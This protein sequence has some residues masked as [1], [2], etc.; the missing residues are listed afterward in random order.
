MNLEKPT[1][2]QTLSS[3]SFSAKYFD[4][5]KKE[6]F[7]FLSIKFK[8]PAYNFKFISQDIFLLGFCLGVESYYKAN[9]SLKNIDSFFGKFL[10]D[11]GPDYLDFKY[12]DQICNKILGLPFNYV[13]IQNLEEELRFFEDCDLEGFY[14]IF[15]ESMKFKLRNLMSVLMRICSVSVTFNIT[16]SKES[17]NLSKNTVDELI[18]S[19]KYIYHYIAYEERI[20]NEIFSGLIMNIICEFFSISVKQYNIKNIELDFSQ[21]FP[22]NS[23]PASS[24]SSF[25]IALVSSFN[26]HEYYL[27]SKAESMINPQPLN[28]YDCKQE[29]ISTQ[30]AIP[31][32]YSKLSFSQGR[33]EVNPFICKFC[34]SKNYCSLDMKKLVP[35]YFENYTCHHKFCPSCLQSLLPQIFEANLSENEKMKQILVPKPEN[36]AKTHQTTN[37]TVIPDKKDINALVSYHNNGGIKCFSKNCGSYFSLA[38]LNAFL[39]VNHITSPKKLC[40]M[41]GVGVLIEKSVRNQKKGAK[42]FTC[43]GCKYVYCATHKKIAFKCYCLCEHCGS[44]LKDVFFLEEMNGEIYQYLEC[45]KCKK[46]LCFECKQEVKKFLGPCKCKCMTCENKILFR[47]ESKIKKCPDC[48]NVCDECF[49]V[50]DREKV[51]YCEVC[52]RNTCRICINSLLSEEKEEKENFRNCY[53][54]FWG[55]KGKKKPFLEKLTALF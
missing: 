6:E 49:L 19:S 18:R 25:K 52:N 10:Q 20:P 43:S 44:A 35:P 3:D 53:Y 41:C 50:L 40:E 1:I 46:I 48:L 47:S 54:C 55:E 32:K 2:F 51:S 5:C 4:L 37:N 17:Q 45:E 29:I 39:E 30:D 38:D 24:L 33:L 26:I 34:A 8:S 42:F 36:Q 15:G 13:F 12:A 22:E 9:R 23:T 16:V 21:P 11:I 14:E 28:C 7:S 27:I 31:V